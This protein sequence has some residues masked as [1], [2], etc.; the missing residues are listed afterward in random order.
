MVMTTRPLPLLLLAASLL[1]GC[2]TVPRLRAAD[3]VH[4]LL[5]A[6]RDGDR[7]AFEAHV[8]RPALKTQLKSRLIAEAGRRGGSWGVF[9]V[10]LVGP[11]VD[12]GVDVLV[13]PDVFRAEAIRLGYDPQTPIPSALKIAALVKPLGEGRA[14]VQEH[15]GGAC[16]LVFHDVGGEYRLSAYE[17]PLDRLTGPRAKAPAAKAR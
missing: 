1:A 4:A 16:V 2:A 8:D 6:V 7:A 12:V 10:S 3:D 11:L 13:Q 14:C 15:R 5:V 9:G 17:G